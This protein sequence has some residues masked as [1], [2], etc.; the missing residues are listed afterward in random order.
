MPA[1]LFLVLEGTLRLA[2]GGYPTTFFLPGNIDGQAVWMDNRR[3]A[4]RFMPRALARSPRP[5]VVPRDK[6]SG[7][8]RIF[9]LGESAALGIPAPEYGFSRMLAILLRERFP[10]RRIEVVNVSMVAINSHA[11]L[12]IAREC[13]RRDGD[14]WVVYMGNNEV[15]GPFG[16]FGVLGART[17]PLPVIRAS[18]ALKRTRVGQLLD[19][20]L[21]RLSGRTGAPSRW[22]GM[23]M[24][25]ETV[26]RGDPRVRRV[27][28]NFRAN[29]ESIVETGR[30]AGI[31]IVLSTVACNLKDCSPLA[32][33]HGTALTPDQQ[34]PWEQAYATGLA[35]E[36]AGRF[37]E[38]LPC[39]IQAARL[40]DAFAEL[41]FRLGNCCL[42]LGRTHEARQHFQRAKDEDA[43]PFRP[44][45]RLNDI[46]RQVASAH[47]DQSVRLLDAEALFADRSPDGIP[48]EQWF[49]EHVHLTP[50]GNYLLAVAAAQQLAPQLAPGTPPG[51]WLPHAEC[52]RRLG[53]TDWGR[54]QTLQL[55]EELL[56]EPPF[57]R[58]TIHSNQLHK[59][60]AELRRLRPAAR[61][62]G[63]RIAL[64]TVL[65]AVQRDPADP[66]L[67]RVLAPMLEAH[68]DARGAEQRWR[69]VTRLLPH[70]PIPHLNLA[71][72]L[73]R[74]DRH[75]EAALAYEQCLRLDPDNAEAH[76]DLGVLRLRQGRP[77]EAARH[78]RVVTRRQPESVAGHWQ[79]GQALLQ[80]D[81]RAE[82]L[83][84]FQRVLQLDPNHPEAR[85][86]VDSR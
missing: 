21:Q 14:A 22:R 56:G 78:L 2:G 59:L 66:E 26:G 44:D 57:T 84:Q 35:H 19:A 85:R 62:S 13:A 28:A 68:G 43:L 61:P 27:H 12:P 49:H 46:I 20:G 34:A 7:T 69:E 9:V 18:L 31:P 42:A 60:R 77:A 8:L 70:A 71:Q 30:G 24:W 58:Q 80:L 52:E 55:V 47:A 75:D 25:N 38:A 63:I 17:P 1:A 73:G 81:R 16:A 79:L 51:S 40:D 29:L 86:L 72:L 6:H 65:A 76:G 64:P 11:I 23:G 48:G 5:L 50:A 33:A 10:G 53:L 67:L 32:S 45:T 3:F 82:A 4:W 15:I 36:A 41:S 37:A 83:A 54:L 74:Q 39:Y